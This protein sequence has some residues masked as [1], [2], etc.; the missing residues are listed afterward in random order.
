MKAQTSIEFIILLAAVSSLSVFL[1][2]LY[3]NVFSAER[4]SFSIVSNAF[5]NSTQ[6]MTNVQYGA[7]QGFHMSIFVPNSMY[8]G[9]QYTVQ[10]AI[11][12]PPNSSIQYIHVNAS[13]AYVNPSSRA[14]ISSGFTVLSFSVLPLNPGLVVVNAT[15][16][17]GNS[18][19]SVAGISYASIAQQSA[20]NSTMPYFSISRNLES[21]AYNTSMPSHIYTLGLWSH[22]SYVSFWGSELS[23]GQECG[24][25]ASWYFWVGSWYCTWAPG[26]QSDTMTYCVYKQQSNASVQEILQ[27]PH[28]IFSINVSVTYNNYNLNSELSSSVPEAPLLLKGMKAGNVLVSDVSGSANPIS[29]YLVLDKPSGNYL[30]N[31]STYSIM[32]VTRQ[33]LYNEL[34]YYN[35]T[36]ISTS[37]LTRI[38]QGINSLNMIAGSIINGNESSSACSVSSNSVLC[39]PIPYLY[40]TIAANSSLVPGKFT[41]DYEGS[42]LNIN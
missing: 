28:Y 20:S 1:I 4:S 39:N 22:C 26:S 16:L 9:E 17:L 7:V 8:V 23:I 11:Y 19:R 27:K 18:T 34:S 35:G 5:A 10:L 29:Q 6:N 12:V 13:N 24:A 40:Y 42:I 37:T 32:Q 38:E 36:S 15:A 25:G 31:A 2:G 41:E 21:V 3:G 30:E 33:N 14:N